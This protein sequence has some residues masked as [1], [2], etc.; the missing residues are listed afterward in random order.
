MI[1]PKD[2][3]VPGLNQHQGVFGQDYKTQQ[4]K[5]QVNFRDLNIALYINLI[6]SSEVPSHEDS[7][8]GLNSKITVGTKKSFGQT[9]E[10]FQSSDSEQAVFSTAS[11][12][13]FSAL[14]LIFLKQKFH[15]IE[16]F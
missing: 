14:P 2:S 9:T 1:W 15:L 3:L 6:D 4:Q 8:S 13:T 10:A 16:P 12:V 11:T 7:E 5:L